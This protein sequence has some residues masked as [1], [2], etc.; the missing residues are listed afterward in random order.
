MNP[1]DVAQVGSTFSLASP[2]FAAF[3][4]AALVVMA[5]VWR[6]GTLRAL[7]LAGLNIGFLALVGGSWYSWLLLAGFLHIAF[8]L[9][10]LVRRFPDNQRVKWAGFAG[11]IACWI[12]L[13]L[14]KNMD[15]F[16]QFTA[17]QWLN[18]TVVGMSYLAFRAIS[19]LQEAREIEKFSYLNYLNYM[20]FFPTLLA[21]P[22]ERYERFQTDLETPAAVDTDVALDAAQRIAI[23]YVK[24]F[25]LADNLAPLGIFAFGADAST[26]TTPMLWFGVVFQ[27]ALIYLDFSGYCDIV[28]GIARLMGF[29]TQENF[30][31]PYTAR[32]I[33]DFWNRWHM[34]LTFFVRDYVFTPICRVIFWY[35]PRKKQFPYVTAAYFFTMLVI[36]LW[37]KISWGFLLF[38]LMHGVALTYIQIKRKYLDKA[39]MLQG[40]VGAFINRP[41]VPVA[42]VLTWIFFSLSTVVWFFPITTTMQIFK[43]LVG[44]G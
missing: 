5:F 22:I 35:V 30:D 18:A 37:H 10:W 34:S 2:Q 25:V 11:I 7:A 15:V 3:C 36:A 19:T 31:R 39:A 14:N 42:V 21:G 44:L 43:R 6:A 12:A 38:G 28:I 41:P 32:N 24:K 4:M 16:G 9:T 33:Q 1:T 29:Q 8:G 20:L 17:F 26:V 23:G 40:G 13:F 27:L